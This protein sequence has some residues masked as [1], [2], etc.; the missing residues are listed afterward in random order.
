MELK[1]SVHPGFECV[2]HCMIKCPDVSY[3]KVLGG[4]MVMHNRWIKNLFKGGAIYIVFKQM[5]TGLV[6]CF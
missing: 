3:K 4:R 6:C 5:K 1:K 2:L